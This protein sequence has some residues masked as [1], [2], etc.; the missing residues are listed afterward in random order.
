MQRRRDR[1]AR[2]WLSMRLGAELLITGQARKR[3]SARAIIGEAL[4]RLALV[5]ARS[6]RDQAAA[7][8]ATRTARRRGMA[9]E[10]K[11][12]AVRSLEPAN[13]K[14]V[15]L[16]HLQWK[17]ARFIRTKM[18]P[19]ASDWRRP[20]TKGRSMTIAATKTHDAPT[21]P[22]HLGRQPGDGG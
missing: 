8:L 20:A 2:C 14:P 19:E 21:P 13:E 17:L 4:Q 7:T 5:K 18:H 3:G 1:D 9:R 10:Q 12:G 11:R 6:I 16:L 15:T 22:K